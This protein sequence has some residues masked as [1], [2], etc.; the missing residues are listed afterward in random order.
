MRLTIPEPKIELYQDGFDIPDFLGRQETGKK[1]SNL[2]EQIDDPLVIA[3]DGAW[4]SGKSHFLKRWVGEHIKEQYGRTSQTVYFDAFQHD[5]LDDPLITLTG[6]IADRFGELTANDK[7]EETKKSTKIKKAA[8]AI[9]RGVLRVGAS[10]AT[11]GATEALEDVGDAV[12]GAIGDEAK[13]AISATSFDDEATAFWNKHSAQIAAMQA[14]HAALAELTEP[15]TDEDEKENPDHKVGTPSHKLVIV[16]DELDRCRPD[17]ALSL[18]ETIK[19]FFN[20]DGVHFVLGVNLK[21]LQN[22]VRARYGQGVDA[23]TYLQ[24]FIT[25]TMDLTTQSKQQRHQKNWLQYYHYCT[26]KMEFPN[27]SSSLLKNLEEHLSVVK[28]D[29]E[30]TLRDV[31]RTLTALATS[32][33]LAEGMSNAYATVLAALTTL[34]TLKPTAYAQIRSAQKATRWLHYFNFD[35]YDAR[36]RERLQ[37]IEQFIVARKELND[38][39]EARVFGIFDDS[40]PLNRENFLRELSDNHLEA[41]NL[42]NF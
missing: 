12:A 40:P 28:L 15:Y 2:V 21:E 29:R 24:K 42:T 8:W 23:E 22:S 17:Y 25:L 13:N 30:L 3:L 26:E 39:E 18:L 38:T 4:G 14:F 19:H 7:I 36:A 27:N 10:M 34:K 9:G 32:P 11:F 35:T 16:I 31:E 33:S 41:F 6:V 1:L 20:V 37:L 5:F